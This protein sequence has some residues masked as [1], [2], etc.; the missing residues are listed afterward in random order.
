M[1]TPE[2]ELDV[3]HNWEKG[4]AYCDN[5]NVKERGAYHNNESW[6]ERAL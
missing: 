4:G 3:P 2:K 5:E 1:G 6:K